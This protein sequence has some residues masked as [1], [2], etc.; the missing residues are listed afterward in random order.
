MR[1]ARVEAVGDAPVGLVKYD[2]LAPDRPLT[3]EGPVV[4]AQA[5][6][7]LVAAGYP[8]TRR[9][10]SVQATIFRARA[11]TDGLALPPDDATRVDCPSR[12]AAVVLRS[13][14]FPRA[15]SWITRLLRR[16]R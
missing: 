6:G 1:V 11:R 14:L 9:L 4:D 8:P 12:A 3:G 16:A 10:P 5:I 13:G 15:S 2:L 7:K